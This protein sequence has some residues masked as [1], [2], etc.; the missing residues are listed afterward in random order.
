MQAVR[1]LSD[2]ELVL[3]LKEGDHA[4]FTEIYDRFK[5]VLY[6]H[7]Y[8]KLRSRDDAKDI[9]QEIFTQLWNRRKE[10][11]VKV[12]L[13]AYL[14]GAV[15]NRVLKHIGRKQLNNKYF[16]SILA[17]CE[18]EVGETDHLIR[19]RQLSALIEKEI[20]NLPERMREVFILSR[21]YNLSHK[22]I[23]EQLGIA[24]STVTKQVKNALK[25]LRTRLGLI[26]YLYMIWFLK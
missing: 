6:A 1:A 5:A 7:L 12:S 22:E 23:A 21:K 19:E 18:E 9:L 13:S 24:E 14:Y 2:Q 15:R 8:N 10:V 17:F 16:D 26:G 20:D 25:V 4:A 11:E 3:L